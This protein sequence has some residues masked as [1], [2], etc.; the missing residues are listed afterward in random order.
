MQR[1]EPARSS[2]RAIATRVLFDGTR[3]TGVEFAPGPRHAAPGDG[4]RGHLCGGAFNSPAAAAALGRRQRGRAAAR[5]ASRS[6]TTCPAWARTCRTTSRSTSST[7]ARS[8]CR[9]SRRCNCGSR[10]WIGCAVAVLAQGPG[11]T[12]PLRGRRLRPQQRRRGLPERDVPLPAHRHPLRRLAA[13]R[14]RPRLPGARRPDVLRRARLGEDHLAPTR[15]C[16]RRCASTTCP[17]RRTGASGSRRPASRDASSPSRRSR[18]FDG[19]ELSPGP[20]RARPTSRSSTGCAATPR[21]RCTRPARAAMGTG[22]DVGG[23]SADDDGARRSTACAWSTRR[24]MPYVTNGNI[25]APVMMLAEKAA[26]LI[27]GNTPLPPE[28]GVLP[29][30]TRTRA[31][32][33]DR[34]IVVTAAATRPRRVATGHSSAGVARIWRA[35]RSRIPARN[36]PL[37]PAAPREFPDSRPIRQSSS[38]P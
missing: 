19:G 38:S 29:S 15:A 34:T 3:A 5:S 30:R 27:A 32:R 33:A 36:R 8:R 21:P 12:Q 13:R 1:P 4:R 16:T 24:S 23:R 26:D 14:E 2:P 37:S 22:D 17:P 7:R 25:Y 35:G 6:S 31:P 20:G 10:P 9:C 11:A 28:P 18:A